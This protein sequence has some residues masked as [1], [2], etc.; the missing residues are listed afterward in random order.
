MPMA[1]T[2][3]SIWEPR[4]ATSASSST[5]W[6]MVWNPSVTRISTSSTQ[7]PKWPE[8]APISTPIAMALDV[9]TSI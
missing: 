2:M 4:M 5:K 7:P 3:F 6:G 9:G 8:I 1:S